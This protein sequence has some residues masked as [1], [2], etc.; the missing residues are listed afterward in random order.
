MKPPP[1]ITVIKTA[2]IKIAQT[3]R[4]GGGI[5]SLPYIASVSQKSNCIN[6]ETTL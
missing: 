1:S 3:S 6:K 5:D 4:G 2:D